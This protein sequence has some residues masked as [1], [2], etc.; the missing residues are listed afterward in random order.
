M[1]TRIWVHTGA[2][3]TLNGNPHPVRTFF[4]LAY[5]LDPSLGEGYETSDYTGRDYLVVSDDNVQTVVDILTEAKMVFAVG[6]HNPFGHWQNLG[7]TVLR[8][9]PHFI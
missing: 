1:T 6:H 9:F 4:D 2:V 8:E 5:S 3:S 7:D